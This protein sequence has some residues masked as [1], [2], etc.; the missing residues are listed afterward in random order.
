MQGGAAGQDEHRDE[1]HPWEEVYTF[2]AG[3]PFMTHRGFR[4]Q[5]AFLHTILRQSRAE[6]H[7]ILNDAGWRNCGAHVEGEQVRLTRGTIVLV[8]LDPTFG[9]EQRG[10]RPCVV[11]TD[12]EVIHDQRYPMVCVIPLTKTPGEGAL[13][14]SL[15]PGKSGLRTRS[16]ALVDQFRSVDK[17]RI[18]KL[19]GRMSSDEL[20]AIEEGLRLF[21]GIP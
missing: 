6:F 3:N 19:Y 18:T 8:T 10:N 12:P 17:R 13:Y 20:R 14:P 7:L 2:H 4:I 16:Y 1:D 5:R 11:L 15:S 21:L 9:H